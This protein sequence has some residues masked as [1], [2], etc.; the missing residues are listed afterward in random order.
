MFQV[1][2]SRLI[3]LLYDRVL[4]RMESLTRNLKGK[5]E[6]KNSCQRSN[7]KEEL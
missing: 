4:T 5:E 2:M 1:E 3:G 6:D 7:L